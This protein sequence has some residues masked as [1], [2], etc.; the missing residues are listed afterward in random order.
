MSVTSSSPVGLSDAFGRCAG[1]GP[2]DL[3]GHE[4]L[5]EPVRAALSAPISVGPA[6]QLAPPL[7]TCSR[8]SRTPVR[9]PYPVPMGA[10]HTASAEEVR[11]DEASA[12]CVIRASRISERDPEDVADTGASLMNAQVRELLRDAPSA[13][14]AARRETGRA[15]TTRRKTAGQAPFATG[16][17]IAT[18]STCDVIGNMP[19]CDVRDIPAAQLPFSGLPEGP[20]GTRSVTTGWSSFPTQSLQSGLPTGRQ[21]PVPRPRR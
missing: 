21:P 18:H 13:R 12:S 16:S 1:Q 6:W 4:S 17:K 2:V 14:T 3:A 10:V 15:T 19:Q 5:W 20:S 11:E 9:T 7:P 8:C